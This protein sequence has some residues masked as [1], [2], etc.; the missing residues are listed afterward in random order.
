MKLQIPAVALA[1]TVASLFFVSC[2]TPQSSGEN[3]TACPECRVVVYMGED[4]NDYENLDL[5]ERTKQ[6]CPGCEGHLT[7]YFKKGKFE[8][9]C[10]ICEKSPYS[11][12][13]VHPVESL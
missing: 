5:V 2:V 13:V 7:R 12:D 4:P 8:H 1:G 11:C 10:S 6:S 9:G 3:V